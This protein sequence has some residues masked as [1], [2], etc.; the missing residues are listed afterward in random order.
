[1]L[2][3]LVAGVFT[4]LVN[5]L[6]AL[7]ARGPG[8]VSHDF[9]PLQPASYISLTIAGT[10]AGAIAW[11]LIRR[12]ANSARLLRRLVPIVVALSLI[13]D[14]L[15]GAT[16]SQPHTTW[17]GVTA[18]MVMHVVVASVAILSYRRFLPLAR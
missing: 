17:T 10:I 6:V 9:G 13:P 4:S 15:L 11:I 7:L 2:S 12:S 1:V 14:V 5:T 16:R 18:L 3:V 8:G